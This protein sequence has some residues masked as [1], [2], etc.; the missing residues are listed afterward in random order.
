M[1]AI[2][3]CPLFREGVFGNLLFVLRINFSDFFVQGNGGVVAS[4]LSIANSY[5]LFMD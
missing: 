3:I 1:G 5:E 2:A 4:I